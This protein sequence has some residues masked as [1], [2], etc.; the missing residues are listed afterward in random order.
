MYLTIPVAAEKVKDLVNYCGGAEHRGQPRMPSGLSSAR[1]DPTWGGSSRSSVVVIV[2]F[3][4]RGCEDERLPFVSSPL[5]IFV[6]V[7]RPM[8][9]KEAVSPRSTAS[10]AQ[11]RFRSSM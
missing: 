6:V 3:L 9:N 2:A 10:S 8:A 1:R 4:S 11:G 7:R 5:R